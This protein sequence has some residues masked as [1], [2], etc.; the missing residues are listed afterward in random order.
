MVSLLFECLSEEMPAASQRHAVSY[1]NKS[2]TQ[3]LKKNNISYDN[4]GIFTTPCRLVIHIENI[5]LEKEP[6][7]VEIKGPRVNSPEVAINGFLKKYGKSESDLQIKSTAKGD[8]YFLRNQTD[9]QP[10]STILQTILETFLQTFEWTKSM[11]W[12]DV[13]VKWIRPIRSLLCLLDEDILPVEF[14]QL[15]ASNQTYGHRF[16]SSGPLKIESI[17]DYFAQLE[18]NYVML[19]QED[20]L[21]FI[22]KQSEKLAIEKNLTIQLDE[23]LLQEV[24]GLVEHPTVLLGR[25]DE[26]FMSLPPALL[27][28]VMKSHQRYHY[29]LDDKMQ[30]APF[31]IFV[32][33]NGNNTE[34]THGNEKVLRARLSDAKFLITNDLRNS[35]ESYNT[36]LKNIIFHSKLGSI[37]DKVKRITLLAKFIAIWVPNASIMEIEKGASLIK[38][39]LATSAVKE[40]PELQGI[41]GNYYAQCLGEESTITNTIKEHYYPLSVDSECTTNPL[42]I[43]FSIADRIDSIVGMFSIGEKPSSSRDPFALRR[44]A[45]AVIRTIIENNIMLPLDLIIEKSIKTYP[46]NLF[47]KKNII[48]L[49]TNKI[50]NKPDKE[51]IFKLTVEFCN[52]RLRYLIKSK[53]INDNIVESVIKNPPNIAYSY[54]IYLSDFVSTEVGMELL[55]AYKRVHN[56]LLN[57]EKQKE[58]P[59]SKKYKQALFIEEIEIKLTQI[60]KKTTPEIKR[61]IRTYNIEKA[62]KRLSALAGPINDFIDAVLI[63]H[64]NQEIRNNRLHILSYIR[65]LF[66]QVA[67][68]NYL[69]I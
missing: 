43:T 35:L 13:M 54:A 39:D 47:A 26:D 69:S 22:K 18:K 17:P 38:A 67:N 14:A 15:K 36:H 66:L 42:A 32:S 40:F 61:A 64:E 1:T 5:I 55:G 48:P 10:L 11:R 50:S 7:V 49:S 34:V 46:R 31:F 16:K 56:I 68:F 21:D 63:N 19:N 28:I 23:S 65:S 30:I 2:I 41:I 27:M 59:I 37:F 6:G 24:V 52:D 8:F 4:I 20:R 51:N 53:S 45:T 58:V 3:E 9:V 29:L 44:A 25:I 60:L 33:N 57:A 62:L 12:S